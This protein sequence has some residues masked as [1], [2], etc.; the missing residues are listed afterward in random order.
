MTGGGKVLFRPYN[1]KKKVLSQNFGKY[2]NIMS[3]KNLKNWM[4]PEITE[5]IFEVRSKFPKH[6]R[7]TGSIKKVT[8]IFWEK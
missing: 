2:Q 6:V 1:M 7:H 3:Q 8:R 4:F 5:E